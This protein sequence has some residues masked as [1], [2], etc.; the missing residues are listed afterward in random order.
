VRRFERFRPHPTGPGHDAV[1]WTSD[2]DLFPNDGDSVV[3]V[4]E[5]TAHQSSDLNQATFPAKRY[6]TAIPDPAYHKWPNVAFKLRKLHGSTN[7]WR[8]RGT[9]PQGRVAEQSL[10]PGWGVPDGDRKPPG[11]ERVLVPPISAKGSFY[12]LTAI[13]LE[14]QQARL[15][16]EG[17]TVCSSSATACPPPTSPRPR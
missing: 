3:R 6:C 10:L 7:W 17:A 16:L 15:A 12:D 4:T 13:R 2:R 8:F 9:D 14:W 5:T 1:T 11:D